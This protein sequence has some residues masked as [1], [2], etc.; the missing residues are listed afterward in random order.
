MIYQQKNESG[1]NSLKSSS[2]ILFI[3]AQ[4]GI[5]LSNRLILGPLRDKKTKIYDRSINNKLVY[6]IFV[7]E[8]VDNSYTKR[9]EMEIN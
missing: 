1:I 3:H 2:I 5:S 4:Q 7:R 8:D 6:A 9:N